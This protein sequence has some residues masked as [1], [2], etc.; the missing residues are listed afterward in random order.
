MKNGNFKHSLGFKGDGT[1]VKNMELTR[2][3]LRVGLYLELSL[4]I[5]DQILVQVEIV[6]KLRCGE[7]F[8]QSW[9]VAKTKTAYQED[10]MRITLDDKL[11]QKSRNK[12][13]NTIGRNIEIVEFSSKFH[14]IINGNGQVCIIHTNN[15]PTISKS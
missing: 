9:R 15:I 5:R 3:Y 2:H 6:K 12:E 8:E 13:R 7:E 4:I 1:Q 14:S 10:Q 11:R